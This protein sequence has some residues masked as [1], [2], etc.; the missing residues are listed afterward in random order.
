MTEAVLKY[1]DMIFRLISQMVEIVNPMNFTLNLV[2]EKIYTT[3]S[4]Q[5]IT[6]VVY[7][8]VRCTFSETR[9]DSTKASS[10]KHKKNPRFHRHP[11]IQV[12]LEYNQ[13]M[14]SFVY[15]FAQT[16]HSE[17]LTMNK[18]K[19]A[20]GIGTIVQFQ[21]LI[22]KPGLN[23]VYGV[24]KNKLENGRYRVVLKKNHI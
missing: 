7:V 20:L 22:S 18:S 8:T 24:V 11:T 14:T 23:G 21:N 10:S 1:H 15:N 5:I 17:L 3:M 16:V 19:E 13:D 12:V 6:F 4:C 2:Y 9:V